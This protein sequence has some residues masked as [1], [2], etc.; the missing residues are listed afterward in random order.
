[1]R[2]HSSLNQLFLACGTHLGLIMFFELVE[3]VS[4]LQIL[5]GFNLKTF[6]GDMVVQQVVPVPETAPGSRF[7]SVMLCMFWLL[8]CRGF[9]PSILVLWTNLALGY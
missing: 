1:M 6:L 5:W 4:F 9:S 3:C 8:F 7:Q 2:H